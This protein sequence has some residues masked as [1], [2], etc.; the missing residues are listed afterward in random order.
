LCTHNLHAKW[1]AIGRAVDRDDRRRQPARRG[2][3]RPDQLVEEGD[4]PGA[5]EISHHDRVD[6]I[7]Q[8][9]DASDRR[10]DQLNG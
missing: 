1:R 6:L 7:I 9:F 8:C 3:A 10:V 5:V 4:L 2:D